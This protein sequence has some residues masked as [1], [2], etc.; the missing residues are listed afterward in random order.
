MRDTVLTPDRKDLFAVASQQGGYFTSE[1]ARRCGY[2]WALLSHHALRGRF[3]R[4]RRGLYRLKDYPSSPRE[5]VL[6]GWLAVGRDAAV[7]SH[8]SALE[9]LGLSDVVPD[10]VHLTVSRSY[11]GRKAPPGVRMHTTTQRLRREDI[12][13]R[14][15][16]RLTSPTRSIIDAATTGVAPEQVAAAAREAVA[17]G[18]VTKRV[19]EK[20][21]RARGKSVG[22]LVEAALLE[23]AVT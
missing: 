1:Q 15:G 7:V 17:R 8:E 10:R 13:I 3:V 9:L 23:V 19:L 18:L 4:I 22:R 16:I 6:A 21:A 14:D 11:R 20:S 12:I 5:D 2:T